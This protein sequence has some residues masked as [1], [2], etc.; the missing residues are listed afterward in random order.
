MANA[1]A[2]PAVKQAVREVDTDLARDL[3]ERALQLSSAEDVRALSIGA[4][5]RSPAS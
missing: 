5:A 2:I 1:P 3:A 4:A